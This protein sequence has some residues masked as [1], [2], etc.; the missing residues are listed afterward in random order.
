[1]SDKTIFLWKL[2]DMYA[3]IISQFIK[4]LK[5]IW[6]RNDQDLY[7]VANDFFLTKNCLKVLS[8]VRLTL[9]KRSSTAIA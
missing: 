3:L 9:S 4:I 1:M 8:N 5:S 6:I 2:W 7:D